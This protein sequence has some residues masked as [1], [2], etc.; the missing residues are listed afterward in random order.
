M[1]NSTGSSVTITNLAANTQ[2][3]V[4]ALEYNG[5]AGAEVY[6]TATALNN[7]NSQSTLG[8][9]PLT[10]LDISVK[11]QQ[12]QA[13][14]EWT[15]IHEINIAGFTVQHS[16]DGIQWTSIGLVNA[17]QNGDSEH[18]YRFTH[19]APQK[20]NNYYRIEEKNEDGKTAFSKVL[21]IQ[22]NNPL[23][24]LLDHPV[25]NGQIRFSLNE[26]ATV[27]LFSAQ[28]QLLFNRYLSAGSH[29]LDVTHLSKGIYFLRTDQHQL[30][31]I[32]Q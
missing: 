32:I 16:T 7:P 20:G 1:Y 13:L 27:L 6:Y 2:Y 21:F 3:T 11:E 30:K 29:T 17:A 10:W 19:T 9:L 14:L 23:I 28:G 31:I 22:I 4:Q 5:V 15:T 24:W 8:V 25:T 18:R 26:S 12:N